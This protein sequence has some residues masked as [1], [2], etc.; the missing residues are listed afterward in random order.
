MKKN[1][2]SSVLD[3]MFEKHIRYPR[4]DVKQAVEHKS[5]AFSE[6]AWTEDINVGINSIQ[7]TYGAVTG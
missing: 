5:L 1:I 3:L 7:M 6:K 2:G 4:G